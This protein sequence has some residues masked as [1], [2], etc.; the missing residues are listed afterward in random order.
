MCE[1]TY[2]MMINNNFRGKR[3]SLAATNQ[4]SSICYLTFDTKGMFENK[5]K[6]TQ[7]VCGRLGQYSCQDQCESNVHSRV[8]TDSCF[9]LRKTSFDEKHGFTLSNSQTWKKKIRLSLRIPF[10]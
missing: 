9:F 4:L 5:L 7:V 6:A 8:N 3:V 10:D 2:F 1:K